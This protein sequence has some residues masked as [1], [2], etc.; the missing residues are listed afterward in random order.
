MD[1]IVLNNCIGFNWDQAN[2]EK[3]WDKH[4]VSQY[5]CE[6]VFFNEPLLLFDDTSHSQ[7]EKRHYVLGMT[8]NKR[9]LFI[10]F[11]I[12]QQLIRVISARDMSKKERGI[13]EQA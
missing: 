9:R 2:Q 3:N 10:V 7:R 12:R 4:M 1:E 6:Q 8:D 13:Y 5:E 11:T